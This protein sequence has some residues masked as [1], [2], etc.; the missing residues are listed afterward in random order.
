[1][2][3]ITRDLDRSHSTVSTEV[4]ANGGR[5]AYRLW[6]AHLRARK[7]TLRPKPSK[8]A[9]RALCAKITLWLEL[10]WS[11]EEIANRLRMDFPDEPTMQISP[12]TIY[13][14]LIVQGRDELRRELTRCLRSGH[15]K[16][17]ARGQ[18]KRSGPVA[19]MVMLSYR[20]AVVEDRAVPGCWEGDLIIGK[21]G[22]SAV[23]MLAERSTRFI[24]LLR[25]PND[26]GAKAVEETMRA[27][28]ST[29][30]SELMRSITWDQGSEVARHVEFTI[31]TGVPIYFCDPHSPWQQGSNKNTNGLL[32]QYLPKSTDLSKYSLAKT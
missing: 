20:P 26:H 9:N 16:R 12:E 7:C 5:D 8:L 28:I 14:S 18:S 23:G 2:S 13:Q 30:P 25:Q 29:L 1:M 4:K 19:N 24:P 15:T 3:A 21:V 10:L 22:A 6:P 31:A 11:P 27:T 17:R 32:R